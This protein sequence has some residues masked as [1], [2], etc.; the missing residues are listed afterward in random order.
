MDAAQAASAKSQTATK[1]RAPG[2]KGTL[3]LGNL[4]RRR[5]DPLGLYMDGLREYGDIVRFRMGPMTVHLISHPDHVKHILQ[6]R[7]AD[8]P[9]GVMYEV[10]EPS[11]GK[12]LLTSEGEFWRR[13]RKLA[14]PAFHRQRLIGFSKT[15]VEQTEAMLARWRAQGVG[16]RV[17]QPLDIAQ[18]MM[19]LTMAIV[20]LTLFSRDVSGSADAVGASLTRMLKVA[21][22]RLLSS[23]PAWYK[24]P[25]PTRF[26]FEKDLAVLNQVVFDIIAERRANPTDRGDLLSMFMAVKDEETGAQM[27]DTQLRDEV[28]T[29][30]L[31]GHET[32]AATLA[33]TFALLSQHPHVARKLQAEIDTLGGR[34]PTFEDL[35]RLK[36]AERVIQE[37]MR[38]YPPAW[39]VARQP[40]VDDVIGGYHI[41]KDSIVVLSSYITHRHP[42][43][44]ENPEGFDP[45]RFEA[46]LEGGEARAKYAYYPFGGGPRVCI[47][48]AFAMMEAV[49]VLTT[50]LQSVDPLLIPGAQIVPAPLITMRPKYG[51]PVTLKWKAPARHG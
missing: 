24:L 35:P 39:I 36:Y 38:L 51:V 27:T 48:N 23:F 12:G 14:Q 20:G 16:T 9:K 11:L 26:K 8:Y 29:I 22:D 5:S 21:N 31:A 19:R 42:G 28:M 47:G 6:D 43:L 32:T 30:F 37:S 40:R 46:S 7:A 1:K 15:M 4:G 41:P 49:L 34:S 25:T 10:L 3:I 2:P 18:E 33:W 44:W 17:G 50:V 45:D 13:Q